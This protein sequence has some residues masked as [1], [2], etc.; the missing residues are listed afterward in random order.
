MNADP[1]VEIEVMGIIAGGM[2]R[3]SEDVD[4]RRRVLRWAASAFLPQEPES[5]PINTTPGT[6]SL[7]AQGATVSA[8]G[9]VTSSQAR[10]HDSLP[11]LYAAV[12]PASDAARA[13]VVGYWFQVLQGEQ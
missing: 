2:K 9:T 13:L 7:Q 8:T 12:S 6:G 3:L 1:S 5:T 10:S 4:A 11:G